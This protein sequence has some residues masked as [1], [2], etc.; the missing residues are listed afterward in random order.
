MDGATPL[1]QGNTMSAV[2]TPLLAHY[3]LAEKS[4]GACLHDLGA[5]AAAARSATATVV[6]ALPRHGVLTVSGPDAGKFLQGQTTTQFDE[7]NAGQSRLGCYVSLKGRVIA[8]FRAVQQGEHIHL[9]MDAALVGPVQE[10]LGKYIVFSKA[11]LST[12][13]VALIGVAGADAAQLVAGLTGNAPAT[14]DAVTGAGAVSAV[15][16]AG[17]H[18]YLLLLPPEKLADAWTALLPQATPAGENAWALREIAAGVARVTA[19]GSELFQPQELNYQLL[20][21]VSY[22]KGCY[23]GQEIVARLYFRG[24]LKQHT[25]RFSA[26]TS[27][28]PAPGT[29]LYTGEKHV[30]D[31]VI[32]AQ[33]DASTVELLAIARPEHVG[34]LHLG[35]VDGPVLTLLALPYAVPVQE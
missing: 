19:P 15:R 29:A 1:H 6:C 10:R 34:D 33:R 3:P 23:T 18:D 22:N 26:A 8:S 32:A 20:N 30:A 35:A 7:V 27:T 31:V 25:Q 5:E 17:D 9:I 14:V 2:W 11:T 4:G 24:K 13:R 16:V 28:L 21:G 12:G